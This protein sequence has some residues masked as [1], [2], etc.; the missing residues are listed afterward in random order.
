[1]GVGPLSEH[2]VL[3]FGVFTRLSF[4]VGV[5]LRDE[6]GGLLL[7]ERCLALLFDLPLQI[8]DESTILRVNVPVIDMIHV[9]QRDR[10][11]SC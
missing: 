3:P 11:I 4:Q 6:G 5:P 2:R 8:G 9:V 1:M 10:I 7:S